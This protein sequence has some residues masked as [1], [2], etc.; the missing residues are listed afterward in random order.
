MKRRAISQWL[1]EVGV[2]VVCM[3]GALLSEIYK[4]AQERFDAQLAEEVCYSFFEQLGLFAK[5]DVLDEVTL[6]D[7]RRA[8]ECHADVIK[9]AQSKLCDLQ[10]AA[11]RSVA[12]T[13]DY[14]GFVEYC[15]R[16]AFTTAKTLS[17]SGMTIESTQNEALVIMPAELVEIIEEHVVVLMRELRMSLMQRGINLL[18]ENLT[19][20]F[21]GLMYPLYVRLV[22][23][24]VCM[25]WFTHN[26]SHE[27]CEQLLVE[28]RA[29]MVRL[30]PVV[31]ELLDGVVQHAQAKRAHDEAHEDLHGPHG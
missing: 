10:E 26:L 28:Q 11:C 9:V 6:E 27:R 22:S 1:F 4:Q 3:Q 30:V 31:I 29:L 7:V 2:L 25:A 18:D 19:G 24:T 23:E 14:K 16:M 21:L 20:Q 5:T 12:H 17:L 13:T 8:R 15:V